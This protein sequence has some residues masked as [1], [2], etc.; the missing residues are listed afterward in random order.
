MS[1]LSIDHD[2]TDDIVCP[3]CG[4]QYEDDGE[5][6]PEGSMDCGDCHK[7]FKWAADYSVTYSTEKVE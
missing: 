5:Y 1:V 6:G 2:C 7:K 3:W 4:S